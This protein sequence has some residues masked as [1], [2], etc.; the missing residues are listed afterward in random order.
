MAKF[1]NERWNDIANLNGAQWMVV[2]LLA[3]GIGTGLFYFFN[4]FYSQRFKL[5]GDVIALQQQQLSLFAGQR[6]TPQLPPAV[7]AATPVLPS[8]WSLY[9]DQAIDFIDNQLSA[10]GHR[11]Q[12]ALNRLSADVG[13]IHD[14]KL[15][16]LYVRVF[17][18]LPPEQRDQ[19]RAEQQQW[20]HSR[21]EQSE[22]AVESHGGS[23]APL[24]YNSRFTELTEQRFTQLE[25]KLNQT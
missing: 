11:G 13:W 23:L 24:E 17:E 9:L 14:A 21:H 1:L 15:L 3:V 2:L 20:L 7:A 25:Q 10:S 19:F 12:Q 4:W 6:N 8:D 5:Q 16:E 22:A 18:R